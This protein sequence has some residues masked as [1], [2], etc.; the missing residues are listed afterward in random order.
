MLGCNI[1]NNEYKRRQQNICLKTQEPNAK[2]EYHRETKYANEKQ[3]KKTRN[4][5]NEQQ[6]KPGI[7][8]MSPKTTNCLNSL[9][10]LCDNWM[11]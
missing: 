9:Q 2:H 7:K 10:F 11:M 8:R 6:R 5:K 1:K 4:T 3:K